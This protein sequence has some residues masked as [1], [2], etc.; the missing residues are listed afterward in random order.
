MPLTLIATSILIITLSISAIAFADDRTH[1]HLN[2]HHATHL[3]GGWVAFS[4]GSLY[5][6][7]L[8]PKNAFDGAQCKEATGIPAAM[9][10]VTALWGEPGIAWV[11]YSDGQI[12]ACRS[13]S[14]E[15]NRYVGPRCLAARG[16]P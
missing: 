6:C 15:A 3:S 9:Q 13:P 14:K 1:R 5:E 4:N 8:N 2:L 16:I 7:V 12:Y 10:K 11:A